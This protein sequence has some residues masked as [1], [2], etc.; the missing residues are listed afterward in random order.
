ML[1]AVGFGGGGGFPATSLSLVNFGG[2]LI[3]LPGATDAPS[4]VERR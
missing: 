1:R 2:Q 3:E 4:R